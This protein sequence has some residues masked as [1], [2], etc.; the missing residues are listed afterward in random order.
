MKV[1][2]TAEMSH[3][4]GQ[5]MRGDEHEDDVEVVLLLQS[6]YHEA[7]PLVELLDGL[8]QLLRPHKA[9]IYRP[10]CCGCYLAAR[11]WP[12]PSAGAW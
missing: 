6:L 4:R 10:N 8:P 3:Q 7:P 11:L 2:L 1:V 12:V 9:L 5:V